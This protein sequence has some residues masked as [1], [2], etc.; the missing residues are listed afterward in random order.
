MLS[1]DLVE[2][3]YCVAFLPVVSGLGQGVGSNS[4]QIGAKA[5]CFRYLT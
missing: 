2:I 5:T 1:K 4:V 3:E